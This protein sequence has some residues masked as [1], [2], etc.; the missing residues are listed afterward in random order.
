MHPDIFQQLTSLGVFFLISLL[1][2]KYYRRRKFAP[3]QRYSTFAPRFWTGFVDG[4]VLWPIGFAASTLLWLNIPR[5]LAALVIVLESLTW[6]VYTVMMHVRYGATIG[7][8]VTKL[9]VVDFRTEGRITWRQGWLREG[10]PMALSLGCLVYE[11]YSLLTGRLSA[12]GVA[13]GEELF[14]NKTFWILNGLP[15]LWFLAE[16][17]T[18]LTNE[19]RRA[20]HD[21]IAGTIVVRTNVEEAAPNSQALPDGPSLLPVATP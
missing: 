10:L 16:I 3:A 20:L 4:C 15:T 2:L 12:G 19:K 1:V 17:L 6:L 21:F 13:N 9:R 8:M 18:M 14:S 5:V 11:V 7:K